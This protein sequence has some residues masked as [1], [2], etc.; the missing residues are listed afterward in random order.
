MAASQRAEVA[1]SA[2]AAAARLR[3]Q[4][5]QARR[6]T[7]V[8]PWGVQESCLLLHVRTWQQGDGEEA[9]TNAD[10][11]QALLR[12]KMPP[13]NDEYINTAEPLMCHMPAGSGRH[14]AGSC[15]E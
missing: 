8:G 3:E 6:R 5:T 12:Q 13:G 15:R 10:M 2:E 14:P 9:C 11:G 4:L 7:G 1:R